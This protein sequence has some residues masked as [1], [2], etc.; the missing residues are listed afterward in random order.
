MKGD[1]FLSNYILEEKIKTLSTQYIEQ[2]AT[3]SLLLLLMSALDREYQKTDIH[4]T[5]H[6][7][8]LDL[9]NTIKQYIIQF[10]EI[11]DDDDEKVRLSALEDC[12]H[13]KKKLL[14]IYENI[15]QYTSLWNIHYTRI[16][17]EVAIRKY[18]EENISQKKVEWEIFYLDCMEFL[19]TAE[20]VLT[21][22]NRIG[23]LLK[24]I[25]FQIARS[26]YYDMIKQSLQYSFSGE[27]EQFISYSL[28]TF[29]N[30]IFPEKSKYYG[31]YFTELSQW[32]SSR[33]SIVPSELSDEALNE[34]YSDFNSV[35]ENLENIEDMFSC[36][37][38]DINSLI[39]LFYLGYSFSELTEKD[40]SHADLYHTVCEM[41]NGELSETEKEA[42]LEQV[43]NS[44]E[45]AVEPIIDKANDIGHEEIKYMKKIN[46]FSEL[47]DDT[48]KILLTEDFIRS[49]YYGDLNEEL[50]HFDT[51]Q[52]QPP[53]SQEW[54]Q[55][56]FDD[57]IS[58]IKEAF[59]V[60]PVA[61]R[62]A[63]M[64]LFLG[65]LPPMMTVEETIFMIKNAIENAQTFEQKI[66]I[67]DKV[68]MIFE[69]HG[70]QCS[71]QLD[72]HCDCGHDHHHEHHHHDCN[73]GHD[74]H[75]HHHHNHHH[76]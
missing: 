73:C 32:L 40:V 35:F 60:M 46:D 33:Q 30:I 13:L 48:K 39:L 75:E 23:Q 45:N 36:L 15:Y 26:K 47:S 11:L 28:N 18:K 66:L 63:T 65:V 54:K 22:K 44:L 41:F 14:S 70:F 6:N 74:H 19:Q 56:A 10:Q 58:H 20:D 53:A 17:D 68:G 2:Q 69:G 9:Q 49:C 25:P 31:K 4:Y 16:G 3:A 27:S 8:I 72:Q 51:P 5:I 12:I 1:F 64:Q 52:D 21:Q 29:F 38:N 24:C 76:H 67:V 50:F 71:S 57:F 61:A 43:R 7:D 59:S 34:E 62:K 55:K 42:Y 37:F